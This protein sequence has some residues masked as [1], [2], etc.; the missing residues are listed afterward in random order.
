MITHHKRV[1]L[2]AI[3]S[4]VAGFVLAIAALETWTSYAEPGIATSSPQEG[5]VLAVPPEVLNLCFSEPVQTEGEDSW[6]FAVKP[7]GGT[8]L[9]LRIV[10]LP[11][12]SCVDVFPGPAT[13]QGIWEFEWS[14]TAR[15][16]SSKG[17]GTVSFQVGELAAGQTA[18]PIPESAASGDDS[19]PPIVFIALMAAGVLIVLVGAAGFILRLRKS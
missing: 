5:A 2:W 17:S 19:D 10:F 7:G 6:Q 8:S 14:V 16:D 15:S 9:G 11:D 18:L 3:A 12:G 4:A 1:K 13:Q